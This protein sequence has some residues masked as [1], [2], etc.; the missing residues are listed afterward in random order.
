LGH[1]GVSV[2]SPGQEATSSDAGRACQAV[3]FEP[4]VT[5][6]HPDA[7]GR[8]ARLSDIIARRWAITRQSLATVAGSSAS[9]GQ[10]SA[11]NHQSAVPSGQHPATVHQPAATIAE[12]AATIHQ[13]SARREG[14]RPSPTQNGQRV[15]LV[16]RR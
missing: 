6:V 16:R 1:A 8:I 9:T 5:P 10:H 4:F 15:I 13:P 11:M 14:I 3:V 12:G 7:A 2:V